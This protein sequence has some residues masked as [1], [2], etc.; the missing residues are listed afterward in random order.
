M[1]KLFFASYEDC[2][3]IKNS[4]RVEKGSYLTE[5]GMLFFEIYFCGIKF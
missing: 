1:G 5:V 2:K 4:Q 3:V